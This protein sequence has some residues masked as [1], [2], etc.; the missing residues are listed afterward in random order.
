[1]S[2]P[3]GERG[4]S[5]SPG[6]RRPF[7]PPNGRGT[8]PASQRSRDRSANGRA[9]HHGRSTLLTVGAPTPAG[10]AATAAGPENTGGPSAVRGAWR[11]TPCSLWGT[12]AVEPAAPRTTSLGVD[13]PR[14]P[15]PLPEPPLRLPGVCACCVVVSRSTSGAMDE[16]MTK[17]SSVDAEGGDCIH[18]P[19]PTEP[20]RVGGRESKNSRWTGGGGASPRGVE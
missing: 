18:P 2:D 3:P 6:L 19:T 17:Q 4:R 16:Y 5:P 12:D 15:C 9:R 7:P 8:V 1:M 10:P 14:V 20:N 13:L 11:S